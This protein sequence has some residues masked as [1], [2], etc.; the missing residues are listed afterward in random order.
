MTDASRA[1]RA[2]LPDA[3]EPLANLRSV[4]ASPRAEPILV[5]GARLNCLKKLDLDIPLI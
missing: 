4:R 5:R 1:A 2:A 3:G